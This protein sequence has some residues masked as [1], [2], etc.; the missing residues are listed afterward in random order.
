MFAGLHSCTATVQRQLALLL[1]TSAGVSGL[2]L[3]PCCCAR[4]LDHA[5]HPSFVH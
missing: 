3:Q 1:R 2:A 4:H 5:L